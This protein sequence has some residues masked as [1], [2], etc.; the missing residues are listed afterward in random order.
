MAK[1]LR[2]FLAQ[3]SRDYPN[4]L[5]TVDNEVDPGRFEATAILTELYERH[6]YPA[7]L[8][9]RVKNLKGEVSSAQL[10]LGLFSSH[11]KAEAT[12]DMKGVSRLELIEEYVRREQA[13]CRPEVIA[14]KGAPV[15]QVIYRDREVDL[16][17]FP[18]VR[19]CE[20]DGNPYI[21]TA[22]VSYDPRYGYNAAFQRMMYLDENHTAI[23]MSPRHTW[24][25]FQAREQQGEPLPIAVVIGHHPAFYFGSLTMAPMDAD[26]YEIIGGML[27][28]PLRVVASE[29]YGEELLVPADAEI[30]LEGEIVPNVRTVE[31]PFMEWTGYYGPQRLR[32][33]VEIKAITHRRD[34]IYS[35]SFGHQTSECNYLNLAT[36]AGL[37]ADLR[38]V[39]PTTKAV[40]CMGRGYRFNVVISMKK[41]MEGEPVSAALA[42][43]AATDYAKNVIVVDDDIDPWNLAD[44]MW[45]VGMRVQPERDVTI[46][47]GKKGS[48]LDPSS[49]HELAT[50]AMIIDA[51]VPL[52][53]P[54]QRVVNIPDWVEQRVKL[55]DY[56]SADW[57][58]KADYPGT[59]V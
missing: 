26:E 1:D 49:T 12:L 39:A 47:K 57:L 25:Y 44:V 58:N 14:K 46:I 41:R 54:F 53:Q 2:T 30:I 52:G 23:H 40:A 33:V 3:L 51:T 43:L 24:T 42:A 11:A 16:S 10:A 5:V 27:A 59:L 6:K 55:E 32:W 35:C 20:M 50:S 19:H 18:I 56:I 28:E 21:D 37:L 9:T 38:R 31:G 48:T 4:E 29:T 17:L 34:P 13:G 8:F 45:A 15:K 22:V 7:V 36:E